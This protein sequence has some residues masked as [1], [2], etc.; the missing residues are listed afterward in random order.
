MYFILHFKAFNKA[1]IY[2]IKKITLLYRPLATI[3][4]DHE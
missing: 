4:K 1:F 2:F 3:F